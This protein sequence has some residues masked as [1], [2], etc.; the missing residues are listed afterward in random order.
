[1]FN[2][3]GCLPISM[4]S[5]TILMVSEDLSTWI[6]C[7]KKLKTALFMV[8]EIGGNDITM[9]FFKVKQLRRSER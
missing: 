7:A 9:H 5:V 6:G 4:V 8:G 1:M 3:I 2:W